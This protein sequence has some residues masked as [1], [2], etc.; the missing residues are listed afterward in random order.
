MNIHPLDNYP[1]QIILPT[2]WH[3][4]SRYRLMEDVTVGQVVVPKGFVTDGATVPLFL[5]WAFPPVGRYFPAAMAHDYLLVK[6]VKW[7]TANRVF[8]RT[9]RQCRVPTWRYWLMA[10]TTSLYGTFKELGKRLKDLCW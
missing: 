6:G 3:L 5:R 4:Q 8:R 1:V 2:R 10:S 7:S 9:L